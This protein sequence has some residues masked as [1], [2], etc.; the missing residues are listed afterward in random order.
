MKE[1]RA[2]AEQ[3]RQGKVDIDG[4]V[5]ARGIEYKGNAVRQPDGTWRAVAIFDAALLLV[6]VKLTL[7]E[8]V[9]V[10]A[11]VDEMRVL[12][13]VQQEDR[14]PELFDPEYDDCCTR[15]NSSITWVGDVVPPEQDNRI[16]HDCAWAELEQLRET[17]RKI[18][19]ALQGR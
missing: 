16:C 6:E 2:T 1:L 9:T 5:D 3:F 14:T 12:P 7:K 19:G 18:A 10:S 11:R 15:C 17:I 8:E 13:T 4:H